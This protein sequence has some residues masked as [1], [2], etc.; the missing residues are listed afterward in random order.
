MNLAAH[1][2]VCGGVNLFDKFVGRTA[3]VEQIGVAVSLLGFFDEPPR[4]VGVVVLGG[5][6]DAAL[7][8]GDD[9]LRKTQ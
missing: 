4:R 2:S 5:G 8:V 3:S 6:D 7:P 1:V 9:D